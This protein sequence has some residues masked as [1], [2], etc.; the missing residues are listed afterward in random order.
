MAD[1]APERA[2]SGEFPLPRS[3][4]TGALAWT[5]ECHCSGCSGYG[6][7]LNTRRLCASPRRNQCRTGGV[8]Y[9]TLG[10]AWTEYAGHQFRC[11]ELPW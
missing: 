2:C 10:V 11:E 1:P 4:T 8:Q 5:L 6:H 9:F 7:G 3:G